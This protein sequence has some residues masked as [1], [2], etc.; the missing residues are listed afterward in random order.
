MEKGMI[1]WTDWRSKW[2]VIKMLVYKGF[3]AVHRSS[4]DKLVINPW[5]LHAFQC[6]ACEK[7]SDNKLENTKL[8]SLTLAFV[9]RVCRCAQVRRQAPA[10]PSIRARERFRARRASWFGAPMHSQSRPWGKARCLSTMIWDNSHN[11]LAGAGA[12]VRQNNSP[13]PGTRPQSST[14]GVGSQ[15]SAANFG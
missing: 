12:A 14:R 10:S 2:R 4:E 8:I 1:G 9:A 15:G 7:R 13:S 6:I 11:P 5:F 3:M